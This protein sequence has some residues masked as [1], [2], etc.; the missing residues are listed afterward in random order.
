VIVPRLRGLSIERAY[1][2][3]HRAGLRVSFDRPLTLPG[4]SPAYVALQVPPAGTRARRGS[5]AKLHLIVPPLLVGS[6]AVPSEI[7]HHK[8]PDFQGQ[9]ISVAVE[10]TERAHLSWEAKVPA[11][12]AGHASPL[13][14]NYLVVRQRPR[15]GE[16]LALG[17]AGPE[18][19]WLPTPLLVWGS[20]R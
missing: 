15:P 11:L 13:L 10:W 20:Q 3:L 7:R 6:G 12:S 1:E 5:V 19:G 14:R 8:V 9:P 4:E 18:G 17:I 2:C 16:R